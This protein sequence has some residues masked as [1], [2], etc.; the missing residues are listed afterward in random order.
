M[1]TPVRRSVDSYFI[2]DCVK[3]ETV[4]MDNLPV[5]LNAIPRDLYVSSKLASL[6][7]EDMQGK[8][9]RNEL[10]VDKFDAFLGSV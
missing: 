4:V 10:L 9:V 8:M 5:P 1:L 2:T 3:A 7:V 6:S